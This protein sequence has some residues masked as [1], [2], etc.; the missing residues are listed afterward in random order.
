MTNLLLTFPE[1]AGSD[2]TP[3]VDPAEARRDGVS[4]EAL[5]AKTA[6]KWKSGL[7]GWGISG[8]DIAALRSTT[9][10][11]IY[12]PGSRAGVPVNVLGSLSAPASGVEDEATQDALSGFVAGLLGMVGMDDDPLTSREAILL[13]NIVHQAWA[14]QQTLSF[15]ELIAAVLQP[16]LRKLGVFD[17]EKFYPAGER[18]KLAM[19]LNGLLA[20]P[21]FAPWM[22]GAPLDIGAILAPGE[23]TPAPIFYLA[24]LDD[25]ERMFFVTL[26]LGQV[27]TW[28]RRQSG[29]ES[30]RAAVYMDEVFGY[31][32]PSANPPSK[33]PMLTLLKQARAFG[34]GTILSTQNPVDLD[35]KAMSNAGTWMIGRLQT[36]RD[37]KRIVDAIG[38]SSLSGVLAGLDKREFVLYSTKARTPE[39]FTSRWAMSYLRGPFTREDIGRV[40]TPVETPSAASPASADSE[41]LQRMPSVSKDTP[42]YHVHPA[43]EWLEQVGGDTRGTR[44]RAFLGA[45][46]QLRFDER[47]A[48]LDHT[49]EWEALLPANEPLDVDDVIEVDFDDRDFVEQGEGAYEIPE[50][51]LDAR[52]TFSAFEKAIKER[53]YREEEVELLRNRTLKLYSRP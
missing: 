23:K 11:T 6:E 18:T 35:Y 3:W 21:A 40:Q 32:P 27:I 46:L 25:K 8:A 15:E 50:L 4:V 49:V 24:H 20:S 12:T 31:L 9:E 41:S 29:S 52:G 38:A 2:F 53:V 14:K 17:L 7:G 43:A 34:V 16:P 44:Y 22:E 13:T 51:G 19:R 26:L 33:K 48:G 28:M 36:E 1:L 42:V 45:R 37:Q 5:G 30:L 39:T 10:F 47:A